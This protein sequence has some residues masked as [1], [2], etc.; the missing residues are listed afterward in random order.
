MILANHDRQ[1]FVF[2]K[3]FS[4]Q[5]IVIEIF[6]VDIPIDLLKFTPGARVI[7]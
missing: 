7:F 2:E 1:E 5:R 3:S 6:L 4:F